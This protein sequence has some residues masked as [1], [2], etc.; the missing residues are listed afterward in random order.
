MLIL[1]WCLSD[2]DCS[3]SACDIEWNSLLAWWIFYESAS[4][5]VQFL[6]VQNSI[7]TEEVYSNGNHLSLLS[8]LFICSRSETKVLIKLSFAIK[9]PIVNIISLET[10]QY[11]RIVSDFSHCA[12]TMPLHRFTSRLT[13]R[14]WRWKE[15][16]SFLSRNLKLK[17]L[18][19]LHFR[20]EIFCVYLF[21]RRYRVN[22]R[23]PDIKLFLSLR[24]QCKC[25]LLQWC[26]YVLKSI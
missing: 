3:R 5:P 17:F 7:G 9:L 8:A 18:K 20:N 26:Y 6:M 25:K 12:T 4:F 10:F 2:G 21:H 23:R 19:Q 1:S 16:L 15:K 24:Y 22:E 13:F 14:Q 11:E